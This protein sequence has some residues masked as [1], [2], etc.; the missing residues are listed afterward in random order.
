MDPRLESWDDYLISLKKCSDYILLT[1]KHVDD[2][3]LRV[4]FDLINP[5]KLEEVNIYDSTFTKF[6]ESLSECKN[7][8]ELKA[9]GVGLKEIP[10]GFG[11]LTA[12]RNVRLDHN[13]LTTLPQGIG[14]L[15]PIPVPVDPK[16]MDQEF[17]NIE[18]LEESYRDPEITLDLSHNQLTLLPDDFGKMKGLEELDLSHNRLTT[19]PDNFGDLTH[20]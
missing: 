2:V 14:G 13:Q 6:P 15:F 16:Y 7:L 10:L 3:Q 1:L 18:P 5:V 4:I 17:G 19:L 12:L 9:S 20:L 11:N 8:A